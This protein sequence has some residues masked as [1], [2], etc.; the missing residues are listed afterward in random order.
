VKIERIIAIE[1]GGDPN[2]KSKRSSSLLK[3]LRKPSCSL[4]FG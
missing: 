3:N 1:S 2:K 4:V